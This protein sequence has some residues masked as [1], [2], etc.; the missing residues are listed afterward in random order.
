[1]GEYQR[2][3]HEAIDRLVEERGVAVVEGGTGLYLRAAL[4][5]L[6]L[7]PPPAEGARERWEATYDA[8]PGA[9]H[10][11]LRRLDPVAAATVH[12]N[13]RRR[14]VRALEL[15]STGASLVSSADA[16]WGED[17]RRPT[18]VVGLEIP[19][20]VLTHRLEERATKMFEDGVVAEVH[21]ALEAGPISRTAEKA[22]GLR[23]I[24]TLPVAEAREH[25]VVRTR[26]YAAYQRKW[27]RRIPGIVM[28]DADRSP[29][30][31]VNAILDVARAR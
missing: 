16:L 7:P 30:V 26:R 5:D 13:D 19:A 1:V 10:A 20:D 12:R 27:M 22:L 3:A 6:R 31:V 15:A 9:A 24:A 21:A 11:Q 8:D 17:A 25:I 23:E 18:L 2:L 29:E 14:V 28:I 4:A